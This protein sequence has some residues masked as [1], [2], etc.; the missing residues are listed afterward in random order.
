MTIT[1]SGVGGNIG[2]PMQP[3]QRDIEATAW[4]LINK[5]ALGVMPDT[6]NVPFFELGGNVW[7]YQNDASRPTL[8]P[9]GTDRTTVLDE[10]IEDQTW[11]NNLSALKGKMHPEMRERLAADEKLPFA[12]RNANYVILGN[13]LTIFAKGMR[14]LE[15]AQQ[16]FDPDSP[17]AERTKDNQ[18]LPGTAFRGSLNQGKAM[19]KSVQ[20][21]LSFVGPNHPYHDVLHRF[22]KQGEGVQQAMEDLLKQMQEGG[23]PSQ[24]TLTQLANKANAFNNA[25]HRV[26]V[27]NDMQIL[28]S[29]AEAMAAAASALALTPSSPSL[30]FGLKL[31]SLGLFSKDSAL[32]FLGPHMQALINALIDGTLPTLMKQAGTAKQMMLIMVLMG[33]LTASGTLAGHV[34]EYG[35]GRFPAESEGDEREGRVF[36]FQLLL[37]L[38]ASSGML[39]GIYRTAIEACGAPEKSQTIIANVMEVISILLMAL[40]AAEGRAAEAGKLIEGL[41]DHLKNQLNFIESQLSNFSGNVKGIDIALKQ[42]RIALEKENFEG[43]INAC[44]NALEL[45]GSSNELLQGDLEEFTILAKLLKQSCIPEKRSSTVTGMIRA[46]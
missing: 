21:F 13:L 2:G 14:W 32:G 40:T 37:E 24:E 35:L 27:G 23:Q 39:T 36:T 41:N 4:T 20:A 45:A 19:L 8:K 44:G 7:K 10:S 28:G 43:L 6:L 22:A 11:Q 26:F 29:A 12:A 38:L 30:F 16:P 15:R 33:L 17:A 18:T 42:G 3:L 31:G 5:A 34:A 25:F 46:A 1:G 9:M